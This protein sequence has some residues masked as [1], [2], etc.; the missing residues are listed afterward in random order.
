MSVAG[1]TL[2]TPWLTAAAATISSAWFAAALK[3]VSG[4]A[5]F[6]SPSPKVELARNPRRASAP[7]SV[8]AVAAARGS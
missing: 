7:F 4:S 6:A 3:Y 8:N 2:C 5:A 1:S